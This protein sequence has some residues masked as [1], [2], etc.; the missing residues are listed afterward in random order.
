[1]KQPVIQTQLIDLYVTLLKT[2]PQPECVITLPSMRAKIKPQK[3]EENLVVNGLLSNLSV[4][5]QFDEPK[6]LQIV[7]RRNQVANNLLYH[8]LNNIPPHN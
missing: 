2:G 3:C 1:M 5:M 8:P 7:Q 6:I 4:T